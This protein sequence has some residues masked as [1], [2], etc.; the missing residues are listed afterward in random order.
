[1]YAKGRDGITTM[2]GILLHRGKLKAV[3][4]LKV[5]EGQMSVL[6]GFLVNLILYGSTRYLSL[7]GLKFIFQKDTDLWKVQSG[8]K[9]KSLFKACSILFF[10]KE[11]IRGK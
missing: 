2:R 11:K 6:L 8:W 9:K 3:L 7:W 5:Q 4:G 1:M 10:K